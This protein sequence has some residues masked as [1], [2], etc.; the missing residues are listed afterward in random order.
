MKIFNYEELNPPRCSYENSLMYSYAGEGNIVYPGNIDKYNSNNDN[1]SPVCVNELIRKEIGGLV[2][3]GAI[4]AVSGIYLLAAYE[5]TNQLY[6]QEIKDGGNLIRGPY[7]VFKINSGGNVSQIS[8]YRDSVSTDQY[9]LYTC[10][11]RSY[12]TIEFIDLSNMRFNSQYNRFE[13]PYNLSDHLPVLEQVKKIWCS[14]DFNLDGTTL[15]AQGNT[16]LYKYV[17]GSGAY[18]YFR[19]KDNSRQYIDAVAMDMRGFVI[20]SKASM[21]DSS[22]IRAVTRV[23]IKSGETT[24]KLVGYIENLYSDNPLSF[25]DHMN[26]IYLWNNK[27]SSYIPPTEFGSIKINDEAEVKLALRHKNQIRYISLYD[28]GAFPIRFDEDNIFYLRECENGDYGQ[29]P[30][31]VKH[32][33]RIIYISAI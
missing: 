28:E 30:L 15:F 19:S 17:L 21:N 7:P 1:W 3:R 22:G 13:V 5:A 11:N 26:R 18:S 31:V 29:S 10:D 25:M 8:F 16:Q 23:Y 12:N 20:L 2:Y 32:N 33:N 14:P 24:S 6:I 4:E 27:G 9:Y